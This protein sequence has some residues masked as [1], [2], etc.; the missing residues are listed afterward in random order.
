[1]KVFLQR[2]QLLLC[3]IAGWMN[4]EQHDVIEYHLTEYRVLRKKLGNIRILLIDQQRRQLVVR[5]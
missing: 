1:V 5:G 2:W 3:N 4:R